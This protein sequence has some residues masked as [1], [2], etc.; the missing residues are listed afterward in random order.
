MDW[1]AELEHELHST[2]PLV[3]AMQLQV[4]RTDCDASGVH[5][6]FFA[7]LGPNINDKGCAFGGSEASLL[8]LAC[9]STLWLSCKQ[10]NIA[11]DIFVHTSRMVYQAPLWGDLEVHARLDAQARTVFLEALG[12]H[13]KAAQILKSEVFSPCAD[14]QAQ[15]ESAPRSGLILGAS[16]ES[17]FVAKGKVEK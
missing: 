13:G 11:A 5:I 3:R 4:R 1:Q 6:E 9:W 7:P 8:T 14:K 10:A 16:L 17:R 2:I 15:T 12:T